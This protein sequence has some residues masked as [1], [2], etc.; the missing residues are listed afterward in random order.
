MP[1]IPATFLFHRQLKEAIKMARA[2]QVKP[3]YFS[4]GQVTLCDIYARYMFTCLWTQCDDN[5]VH[6]ASYSTIK[7]KTFP[8]DDVK[9]SD[10]KKWIDQLIEQDLIF[11]FTSSK[12]YEKY[13]QVKKWKKHQKINKP[14]YRYPTPIEGCESIIKSSEYS[15]L[16]EQIYLDIFYK[17][18]GIPLLSTE[19]GRIL[20]NSPESSRILGNSVAKSKSKSKSKSIKNQ[21]KENPD[22]P[23]DNFLEPMKKIDVVKEKKIETIEEKKIERDVSDVIDRLTKNID[24]SEKGFR[25][26]GV[27]DPRTE[28]NKL[29]AE[30]EKVDCS[31]LEG[32][33]RINL[34]QIFKFG[35][36]KPEQVQ[37]SINNMALALTTEKGNKY[38]S[39][40]GYLM[41]LFRDGSVFEIQSA[42]KPPLQTNTANS[43]VSGR[44]DNGICKE[45]YEWARGLTLEKV[46]KINSKV[47]EMTEDWVRHYAVEHYKSKGEIENKF[48]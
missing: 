37:Q 35:T 8:S 11:E 27:V 6:P 46:Q 23:V 18:N 45:D 3:E 9:I 38:T 40:I 1:I 4:S 31:K 47:T 28:M 20:P 43:P 36:M 22:F 17:I 13:W 41:K 14:S 39:P 2:R 12:D 33:T 42:S 34:M 21:Q 5:G 10:I 25:W 7:N 24:V 16:P 15:E 29:P 19:F 48:L 26:G 30:W 44:Y 32:F